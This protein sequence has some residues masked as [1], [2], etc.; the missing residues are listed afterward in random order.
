[1]DKQNRGAAGEYLVCGL[2]AELD[3][4]P[5]LT[6]EGIARTDILAVHAETRRM[7]TIQVKT[8]S[9]DMGEPARWALGNKDIVAALDPSEWY[10]MVKLEGPAPAK[11][12]FFVVPRDHVAAALW[13]W[14]TSWLTDPNVPPGKRNA[15]LSSARVPEPVF[16][17]YEDSWPLLQ[18]PADEA[19]VLLPPQFRELALEHRIGLPPGHPWLHSLPEW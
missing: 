6:R 14:H 7:V 19:P 16:E 4:V 8:H 13:I 9:C 1:M 18:Q 15:P 2:L 5:A 12:R 17:G 10:V 3:W 11:S